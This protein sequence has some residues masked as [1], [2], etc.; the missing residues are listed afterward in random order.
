MRRATGVRVKVGR[1]D[2]LGAVGIILS[3]SRFFR[4]GVIYILGR[5][6]GG[7]MLDFGESQKI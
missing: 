4:V 6:K 3:F 5:A 2:F 7:H 1:R